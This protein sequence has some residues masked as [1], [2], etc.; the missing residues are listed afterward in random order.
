VRAL[1]RI[2]TRPIDANSV[3]MRKAIKQTALTRLMV[4]ASFA[5]T[6]RRWRA[7]CS[8]SP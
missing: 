6:P 8:D 7:S 5:P 2:T 4:T 1:Y 3:A